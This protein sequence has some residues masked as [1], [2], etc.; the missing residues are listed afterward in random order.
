MHQG[1][2]QEGLVCTMDSVCSEYAL[3]GDSCAPDI[4]CEYGTAC[5]NGICVG[6]DALI[7][8]DAVCGGQ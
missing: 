5:N 3:E 6:T 1:D 2:C 8:W 4:L 7:L